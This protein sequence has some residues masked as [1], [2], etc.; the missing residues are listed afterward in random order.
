MLV[1]AYMYKVKLDQVQSNCSIGI[2]VD[3]F[4]LRVFR[5]LNLFKFLGAGAACRVIV[6]MPPGGSDSREEAGANLGRGGS[7]SRTGGGP[8]IARTSPATS[9][10]DRGLAHGAAVHSQRDGAGGTGMA[11]CPLSAVWTGSPGPSKVL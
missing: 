6:F 1:S 3:R 2:V 5:S 9:G 10:K 8:G 11:R 7:D 4:I